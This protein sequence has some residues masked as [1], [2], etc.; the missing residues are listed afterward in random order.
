MAS[1]SSLAD[2]HAKIDEEIRAEEMRPMPD[3]MLIRT[4][5]KK[6]LAL[7]EQIAT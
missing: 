1:Q 2:R 6:K 4:L 7:K 3:E 5:K